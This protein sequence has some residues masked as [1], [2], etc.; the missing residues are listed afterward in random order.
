MPQVTFT[1]DGL[2][3]CYRKPIN[4]NIWTF[5]FP[6]D[7]HHTVNF[8]YTKE[9]VISPKPIS[10]A[11]RNVIITAPR[12]V[13]P[14]DFATDKFRMHVLDLTHPL[15]HREGLVKKRNNRKMTIEHAVLDSIEERDRL[16]IAI[17]FDDDGAGV[18][19]GIY[20]FPDKLSKTIGGKINI[21]T[22][23]EVVITIEGKDPIQL[24]DGD[25]FEIDNHCGNCHND[26]RLYQELYSNK[27]K[28]KKLCNVIS[29]D[30][31]TFEQ[32]IDLLGEPPAFCDGS[33]IGGDPSDLD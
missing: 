31:F 16:A 15:L 21:P 9:G 14:A 19:V 27:T 8:T 5:V 17:Q 30:I 1:I 11:N 6:Y 29:T 7:E 13:A 3:V 33:Q 23:G 32:K 24:V 10:L 26:F 22:G 18:P 20:P 28:P 4:S 2:V 25:S 12:S